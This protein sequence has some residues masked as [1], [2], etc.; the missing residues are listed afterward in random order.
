MQYSTL[1]RKKDKGYQFI[2][3]YKESNKWK[4]KSRQGFKKKDDAKEALDKALDELKKEVK[5]QPIDPT[6]KGLTFKQFS[7][8]FLEHVSLYRETNT[9]LAFKTALNNFTALNDIEVSKLSN[10]DIQR[11]VDDLM[12]KGLNT[13][14]IKDYLRKL[15]TVF[16]SA[17]DEYN[18][19]YK[20]P[21]KGIKIPK[22]KKETC[23]RALNKAE[24]NQLLNDFSKSKYYIVLLIAGTCGLRL[25]EIL[26]LTWKDVDFKNNVLK[27]NKQW[28]QIKIDKYDFGSLKSKNSY[29][30][31]PIPPITLNELKKSSNVVNINN[32]IFNFKNTDSTSICINRLLKRK[33]YDI[34]IHELRH[35]YATMLISSGVDFKTA[36]KLLGH[37]VEQTMKTYSHVNDDMMKRATNIIKNI[38]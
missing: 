25:G 19:I 27:V 17:M 8:I 11:S 28:K 9:I 1:I 29:R 30:E 38:F 15:N 23:K 33:G 34:T 10:L 37:T 21:T 7:D 13:N 35:T 32:R 26:G 2:I 16:K 36:A 6:M 18:L 12:R 22:E 14:T 24:F 3:T 4:T 31:V 20:L 5:N